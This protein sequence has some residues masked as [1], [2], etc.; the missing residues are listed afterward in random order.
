MDLPE[1]SARRSP[2]PH[3]TTNAL[4]SPHV[5]TDIHKTPP[6]PPSL[7][8][9]P[10]G[11]SHTEKRPQ[12]VL[13]PVTFLFFISF[14]HHHQPIPSPTP[15]S[16]LQGES[17]FLTATRVRSALGLFTVRQRPPPHHATPTL[18]TAVSITTSSSSSTPHSCLLHLYR[19]SVMYPPQHY[20][21]SSCYLFARGS[22][23]FGPLVVVGTLWFGFSRCLARD[24]LG[25]AD[26]HR[27]AKKGLKVT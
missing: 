7:T 3:L 4:D 8:E 6:T 23:P 1:R 25:Y 14:C 10:R 15:L 13:R 24:A 16:I 19:P 26:F 5:P 27:I 2:P 9:L 20:L 18:P 21:H 17:L 12:M 22:G 11:K